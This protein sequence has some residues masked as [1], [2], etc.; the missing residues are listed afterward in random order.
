MMKKELKPVVKKRMMKKELKPIK[1]LGPWPSTRKKPS[2]QSPEMTEK[3]T[4]D[5]D[6]KS[7]DPDYTWGEKK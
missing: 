5:F 4:K 6:K 2:S 3:R 1:K 7:K